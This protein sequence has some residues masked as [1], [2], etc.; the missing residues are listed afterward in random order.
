MAAL[1]A[2]DGL[3][4]SR[5]PLAGA[6]VAV[7]IDGGLSPGAD[8]E[9]RAH[10]N[11]FAAGPTLPLG[12]TNPPDLR[13]ILQY[14]LAPAGIDVDDIS[15]GRE[16]VLVNAAGFIAVP[17]SSWGVLQ[18]SL[19]QGATGAPGSRISQEAALGSVGAALFSWVLPGSA[20][21]AEVIGTTQR[22]HS[23]Q[24][25][26]LTGAAV[27]VD[28]LDLPVVLGLEQVA[29]AT[30]EPLFQNFVGVPEA[31]YFTVSHGTRDLV[32]AAWWGPGN[33]AVLKS[34]ATI[35]WTTRSAP[36]APWSLPSVFLT[37]GELGLAQ[38]ED[39]DGLAYDATNE[40]LLFSCVGT[41]RDQF[42]FLDVSTDG[43]P[44]PQ[45]VMVPT[46]PPTPVSGSVGKGQLDDVDAVCTLDPKIGSFGSPPP[47]T[48]DDFGSSCGAPRLPFL[49][50]Q[51]PSVHAS[52]FRRRMP[53]MP[54]QT[55][56]DTWMVGWPPNTDITP[57]IALLFVTI[58][59][60]HGAL[61]PVGPIHLRNTA[62][63]VPGN[64][65][66]FALP[67]PAGLSL[68]GQRLTFRWL[69]ISAGFT[70]LAE[71]WPVQVCL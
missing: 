4:E 62:D 44:V 68:T 71:A 14:W 63:P 13:S 32:P 11:G 23:R 20:L 1:P 69:A 36:G 51:V 50:G 67:V 5:G 55:F 59:D 70:E 64:P 53:G 57:G 22:S 65:C 27:E 30:M 26:G 19:R 38:D 17:P 16:D 34:G 21:P 28:G 6:A 60:N 7:L 25:L 47:G 18:F 39:I 37:Y 49:L 15:T 52:A 46:L 29:F 42:L 10:R 9:T 33:P 41:V 54:G 61:F 45:P 48:G 43:P 3:N 24:D 2:Q 12:S 31:I 56:F 8:A 66:T 40:K 58:G 35:L